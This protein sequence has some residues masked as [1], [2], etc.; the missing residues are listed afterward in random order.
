MD[1]QIWHI[2]FDQ[3]GPDIPV[4]AAGSLLEVE[5][6]KE[7][8]NAPVGRVEFLFLGPMTFKE[9]LLASKKEELIPFTEKPKNSIP[10]SIHQKLVDLVKDYYF[11]GGMPEAVKA[12]ITG[13]ND[14]SAAQVVQ[15]NIIESYRQDVRKYATGKLNSVILEVLDRVAFE[16]GNKVKYQN[17]S[18]AKSTYVRQAIDTL[19]DIFVIQKVT[20]TNSAG[21][22]LKRGENSEVFK[23][24]LLDVGIYSCL[25]GIEWKDIV[26]LD[27]KE[28][29]NKGETAE[30]F[31]AQHLY[32]DSYKSIRPQLHYWLR[33][34][35]KSKAE[36]DFV[37]VQD[38]KVTPIEVKAGTSGQ[39]KSLLTFMGEKKELTDTAIRYDLAHREAFSERVVAK[40]GND[41]KIEQASFQLINRPLYTI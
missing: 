1:I 11:V 22:P 36:V 33:D 29:L 40:Y 30:Q 41:K 32:L 18:P 6:K 27:Q 35:S 20:H 12:Y 25:M 10:Y 14:Y 4:I 15:G 24:Y 13:N 23:L 39:I 34:K 17:L 8:Q 2:Q 28:L 19:S 38:S 37:S 5:L 26:A 7:K 9:F 31:I 3:N 16:V 21:I